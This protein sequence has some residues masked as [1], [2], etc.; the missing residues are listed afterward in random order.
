MCGLTS[1][2]AQIS[3]HLVRVMWVIASQAAMQVGMVCPVAPTRDLPP[4]VA[5]STCAP[6]MLLGIAPLLALS[7]ASSSP[8]AP[9]P[10]EPVPGCVSIGLPLEVVGLAATAMAELR[11][12]ELGRP[13]ERV[14]VAPVF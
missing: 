3:R 9:V 11:A 7:G 6:T 10:G 2:R 13:P 14:S 8:L 1:V 5:V 4:L 12:P